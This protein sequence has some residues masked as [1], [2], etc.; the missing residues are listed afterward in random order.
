MKYL[1]I[2]L[3][4]LISLYTCAQ[5]TDWK[6]EAGFNYS[7]NYDLDLDRF[8]SPPKQY[9]TTILIDIG[10]DGSGKFI[11]YIGERKNS[12][13]IESAEYQKGKNHKVIMQ[14]SNYQGGK[15]EVRFT[16]SEKE[17]LLL[18]LINPINNTS[19]ILSN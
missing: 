15:F 14:C 6:T 19:V 8:T 9:H 7:C 17:A 10:S 2:T 18:E 12:F 4:V 3:F 5:V 11:W 16:Y 13:T 1:F